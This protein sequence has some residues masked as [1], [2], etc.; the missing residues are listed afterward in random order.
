MTMQVE[1]LLRIAIAAIC[2]TAIGF[3][4]QSRLKVAGVRTH[5]I[6]ALG[7]ALMMIVSKY[8]FSD[9][10]GKSGVALDPSRIAAQIVSGIGFLGAGIIFVRKQEISGLTTAAGIW[11]TSGV[12]MAIG[13]GMY[14]IGI[15]SSAFIILVQIVLHKDFKWFHVS[16]GE[17]IY[18]QIEDKDGA[19]SSLQHSLQSRKVEVANMKVKKTEK[20]ILSI[21]CYVKFPNNVNATSLLD[22]FEENDLIRSVQF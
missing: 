8:G 17:W 9:I 12:G 16:S 18:F 22:C 15:A 5:L 10:L 1:F 11:A 20:G 14:F 19:A 3:E 2:G 21:E 6:V 13:A 7:A 4:R